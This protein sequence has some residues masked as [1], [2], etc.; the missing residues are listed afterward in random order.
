MRIQKYFPNR[1]ISASKVSSVGKALFK[2][3]DNISLWVSMLELLRIGEMCTD[4]F[5]QSKNYIILE[6][7][8]A[9]RPNS[10]S[11]GGS[12]VASLPKGGASKVFL[13]H[14]TLV[15][16]KRSAKWERVCRQHF[17]T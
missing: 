14:F 12:L 17:Q 13:S 4:V 2:P 7:Q 3:V 11:S 10:S 8:G 1:S 6:F 9:M 15:L 16:P 5:L